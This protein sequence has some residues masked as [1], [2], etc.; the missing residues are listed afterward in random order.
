MWCDAVWCDVMWCDV[1]WCDVNSVMWCS[2]MWCDVMWC[3]IVISGKQHTDSTRAVNDIALQSLAAS[4]FITTFYIVHFYVCIECAAPE[5]SMTRLISPH[6]SSQLPSMLVPCFTLYS[7]Q[8]FSWFSLWLRLQ[9]LL[10]ITMY[11]AYLVFP[12]PL[13]WCGDSRIRC[14]E[15]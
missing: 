10:Y 7:M 2:V 3:V 5:T 15:W 13:C 4:I 9:L 6:L 11:M 8:Q 12:K 1:M 14:S